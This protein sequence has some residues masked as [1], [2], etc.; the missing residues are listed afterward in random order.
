MHVTWKGGASPTTYVYG[1]VTPEQSEMFHAAESKGMAAKSIKDNNV[2]VAK[3]VD[4]KRIPV[5]KP[6]IPDEYQIP[7]EEW[8]AGHEIGT[9]VEGSPR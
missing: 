2:L 3:I 7:P 1:E 9:Q 4:G 5:T 6:A 8:N